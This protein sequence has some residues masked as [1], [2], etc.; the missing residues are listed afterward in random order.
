M[1]DEEAVIAV[2]KKAANVNPDDFSDFEDYLSYQYR[3]AI[4]ALTALG[5]RKI[6]PGEVVV[7][8]EATPEMIKAGATA[9]HSGAC[10][11]GYSIVGRLNAETAYRAM[12][13]AAR[14]ALEVKP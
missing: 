10:D 6:E 9:R 3:A 4:S 12:I 7:P 1:T 13:D 8:V 5:W 14:G 2:M 11:D